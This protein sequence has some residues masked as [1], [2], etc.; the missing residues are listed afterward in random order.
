MTQS[1]IQ[2]TFSNYDVNVIRMTNRNG[3]IVVTI[4]WKDYLKIRDVQLPGN[5]RIKMVKSNQVNPNA[6][7][8]LF[9]GLVLS[10]FG[11]GFYNAQVVSDSIVG[12]VR[13]W[14]S[15]STILRSFRKEGVTVTTIGSGRFNVVIPVTK[16][17]SLTV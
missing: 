8:V 10:R 15:A 5:V 13:T 2:L 7:A 14:Q 17:K 12:E 3:G 1:D 16:I 11:I 4:N 6:P 9:A